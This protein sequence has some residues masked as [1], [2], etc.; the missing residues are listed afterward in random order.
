M[1]LS[2]AAEIPL[3]KNGP[4]PL[5]LIGGG[6]RSRLATDIPA[7][8]PASP[9][10]VTAAAGGRRLLEVALSKIS[11][12]AGVLIGE[13]FVCDPKEVHEPVHPINP[14]AHVDAGRPARS[15][16]HNLAS[17]TFGDGISEGGP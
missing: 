10:T 17:V 14:D 1:S 5:V 6:R 11:P 16:G 13:P 12:K 3:S 15:V 2:A 4:E 9:D 7:G 8:A